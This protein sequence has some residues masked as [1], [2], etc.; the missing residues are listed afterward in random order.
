MAVRSHLPGTR[1]WDG[2]LSRYYPFAWKIV[3]KGQPPVLGQSRP[4]KCQSQMYWKKLKQLNID[5]HAYP[6]VDRLLNSILLISHSN[7]GG[8]PINVGDVFLRY[9]FNTTMHWYCWIRENILLLKRMRFKPGIKWSKAKS[10]VV[11]TRTL[12]IAS[13]LLRKFMLVKVNITRLS[14]KQDSRWFSKRRS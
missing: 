3:R 4:G 7:V 2:T 13:V 9:R 11:S 12:W 5:S 14:Q 1:F 10:L 6:I 8:D